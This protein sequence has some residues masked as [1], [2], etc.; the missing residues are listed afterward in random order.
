[1]TQCFPKPYEPF[2]DINVRVDLSNYMT[3]QGL[4]N[5]THVDTLGLA[6]KTNLANL[7]DNLKSLP[8]NLSNL[9][10]EVDKLDIDNLV[11][12]PFDLSKLSN[13]LKNEVV[14]K[15]EYD[16][17]MKNIESKI[18]DVSNLATKSNLNTKINEVNN[19]IPS[20]TGLA[21]TSA[22]TAVENKI[23][24]INNLVKKTDYD[25]KVSE[26][27]KKLTDHKQNE[28]ITTTEFNARLVQVNL[29][30]KTD[31]DSKI[32]SL[33]RKI[34]SNKTKDIA[35]ANELGYF[36]G[37]N[38]FDEDGTQNYYIFQPI[39]KYLKVA[40]V[41]DINYILSWKS[42]G[43]NGIKIESIKTNDYLLNPRMDHYDMS[44]IR[45]KFDGSFLNRFPPTILHGNIVNIYIVY[46]IT[47]DYKDINYPT[48]ENC[49]FESV[50]LTKN[51]DIDKYGYSGYG[52][53]FDRETSFSI[54]NETGK[55]VIIFGVDMSSS[56]KIDNR[57]K[58]ILILGIGPTQGLENTLSAEKMYSI[59]FTKKMQ[60]FV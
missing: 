56:T 43:L 18:P 51:A 2:G 48:L 7:I 58:D 37:K 25:R 19:K 46:E 23:P 35:I 38:Q 60:N 6:L 11:P 3:K 53:G 47:S 59:N 29:V 14:K 13:V 24:S 39:S 28:Y 4:K 12:I 49:L 9:K 16:A 52:I 55:N 41:N 1:M 45:I 31:F 40:Y 8:N 30:T 50:K 27:D 54:G 57:K 32:S 17:K 20:K 21:T 22:L 33:N 5:I 36:R 10:T 34:V 26:I 44:K 42:R 15:T